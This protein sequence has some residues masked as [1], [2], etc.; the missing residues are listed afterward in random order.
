M[1]TLYIFFLLF[2]FVTSCGFKVVNKSDFGNYYIASVETVG[3]KKVNYIIKNNLL[4]TLESETK[5]PLLINLT[6]E[7]IKS[8][9]EKNI[10]NE[11]TK[12]QI[13]INVIINF[14]NN[15]LSSK[16]IIITKTGDYNVSSQYSQTLKNEKKV[17]EILSDDISDQILT[18]LTEILNDL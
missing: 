1:R 14:I 15:N 16:K 4:S 17:I 10:K 5:K 9:K 3:D 11:I 6:S 2:L 12:Y 8:I 18:Q 7:K 13:T